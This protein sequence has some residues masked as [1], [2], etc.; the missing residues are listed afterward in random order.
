MSPSLTDMRSAIVVVTLAMTFPSAGSAQ[1]SPHPDA[2]PQPSPSMTRD[3]VVAFAK[4]HVAVGQL[5]DSAQGKL[6]LPENSGDAPQRQLRDQLR[7][8]IL[9]TIQRSGSTDEDFRR[10]TYIVSTN[11]SVRW[12]FDSVVAQLTGAPMPTKAAPL[13]VAAPA[14]KV[15]AGA[16]GMHI[17]HVVN[18]F[19]DTPG[20][21]GLLSTALAEARIAILHAGLAA[22]APTSLDAM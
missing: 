9:E 12:Q 2:H 3:Q 1:A 20:G 19:R 17:G 4:V 15:P 22:N 18:E 21:Q 5:R 11:D 16:V 13:P 7:A 6:R 10:K 8:K 14:L